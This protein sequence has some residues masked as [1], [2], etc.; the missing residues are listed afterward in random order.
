MQKICKKCQQPFDCNMENIMQCQC[1]G[2]A[3]TSHAKQLI[4]NT[5]SDCLCKNCLLKINEEQRV[6]QLEANQ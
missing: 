6:I 4:S 3:L 1:Y 2:I 5:F